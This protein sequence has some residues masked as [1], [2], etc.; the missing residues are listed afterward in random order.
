MASP[1]AECKWNVCNVN[2]HIIN[3]IIWQDKIKKTWLNLKENYLYEN[4][5]LKCQETPNA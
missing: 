2:A 3:I 4:R 5:T 1:N